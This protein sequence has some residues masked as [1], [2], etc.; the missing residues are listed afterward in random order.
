MFLKLAM[1]SAPAL[2]G[3][4]PELTE[5]SIRQVAVSEDSEI[6]TWAA[7]ICIDEVVQELRLRG[8]GPVRCW[9]PAVPERRSRITW[10]TTTCSY[11]QWKKRTRNSR[12]A[13]S[14]AY[15]CLAPRPICK[16]NSRMMGDRKRIKR[17][18]G[19]L[20]GGAAPTICKHNARM[21]GFKKRAYV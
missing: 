19:G 20:G 6:S 1:T 3:T 14:A 9:R 8:P 11:V 4:E 15:Q 7:S 13:E 2:G 10:P 17:G 5:G 21:M 12:P 18:G 16:R